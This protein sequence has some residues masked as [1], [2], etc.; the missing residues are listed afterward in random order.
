MAGNNEQSL[1]ERQHS[2]GLESTVTP[3]RVTPFQRQ[4]S[5]QPHK[6][7]PLPPI[8]GL[9]A[10]SFD[11]P[12]QLPGANQR[13]GPAES[14]Q[15]PAT[16]YQHKLLQLQQLHQQNQRAAQANGDDNDYQIYGPESIATTNHYGYYSMRSNLKSAASEF[17][18]I[19]PSSSG[20]QAAP[21]Q[22]QQAQSTLPHPQDQSFLLDS[23]A[24][25]LPV[26]PRPIMPPHYTG[27]IQRRGPQSD[28]NNNSISYAHQE[29]QQHPLAGQFLVH[30]TTG[31][32][33]IADFPPPTEAG[34]FEVADLIGPSR[35]LPLKPNKRRT[36]SETTASGSL[37]SS[38]VCFFRRAFSRQS[39]RSNRNQKLPESCSSSL[40]A[41]DDGSYLA[42]NVQLVVQ[43]AL[44]AGSQSAEHEARRGQS[45]QS[46]RMVDMIE[47]ITNKTNLIESAQQ[48]QRM[49][50]ARPSMSFY[51]SPR[52][53]VQA[54]RQGGFVQR[55][56]F[57]APLHKS[58]SI[59]T[60][61]GLSNVHD[62]HL[63]LYRQNKQLPSHYYDNE[64]TVANGIESPMMS[65]STKVMSANLTPLFAR[66]EQLLDE[67]QQQLV[68]SPRLNAG[69]AEHLP[70]PSS[71]YGQPSMTGN[72]CGGT[73]S[74]AIGDRSNFGLHRSSLHKQRGG[75]NPSFELRRHQM[76]MKV[77]FLDPTCEVAEEVST[78]LGDESK[79]F[80][81]YEQFNRLADGSGAAISS[82]RASDRF[83]HQQQ[84]RQAVVNP[85]LQSSTMDTIYDNH[86]LLNR[87]RNEMATSYSHYDNHH[88][89]QM[90]LRNSSAIDRLSPAPKLINSAGETLLDSPQSLYRANMMNLHHQQQ[91]QQQ[92]QQQHSTPSHPGPR[93]S[94]ANGGGRFTVADMMLA[95]GKPAAIV[96]PTTPNHHQLL[97]Y[98]TSSN[99]NESQY[100]KRNPSQQ[101][102]SSLMQSTA[103]P[104]SS[105]RLLGQQ[106]Q[107]QHSGH[108]QQSPLVSRQ[109]R[110]MN[111]PDGVQATIVGSAGGE[112]VT[113]Q[114]VVN[115]A[116][117]PG[118][119]LEP[120]LAA[121]LLRG[122]NIDAYECSTSGR[123][124]S[125]LSN[126]K[127]F[128]VST[129][130]SKSMA[131]D[132]QQQSAPEEGLVSPLSSA[133]AVDLATGNLEL[134][135]LRSSRDELS[136][137]SR[138]AS[139]SHSSRTTSNSM[140]APS[141]S[142]AATTTSSQEEDEQ[143]KPHRRRRCNE[144]DGKRVETRASEATR[145][146]SNNGGRRGSHASS[147]ESR[148]AKSRGQS[149]STEHSGETNSRSASLDEPDER[150]WIT[151]KLA[152]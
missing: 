113:N 81:D 26:Q 150:N 20:F 43:S 16:S 124:K 62:E 93:S 126:S 37:A 56:Q 128:L 145:S 96:A 15:L 112:L 13:A 55:N 8:G 118:I 1:S 137:G 105:P 125:G 40:G 89:L 87:V 108:Y 23:R 79:A 148:S 139:S 131:S 122:T 130:L 115:I 22:Q 140:K 147:S 68:M 25:Q 84:Q 92:L 54:S 72:G 27:S 86:P 60:S 73:S 2:I 42:P 32:R 33:L 138:S 97:A 104:M 31:E 7:R 49:G 129:R 99:S 39:K 106:H 75:Q 98:S 123:P 57:G 51:G 19:R 134:S 44:S 5:I 95:N 6:L 52:Q 47:A 9:H 21:P 119:N 10:A 114:P 83:Q 12:L 121:S 111:R 90:E 94:A 74:P 77:P 61:M 4:H 76:L 71:I 133:N 38:I 41:F 53:V 144:N 85:I 142:S 64:P 146:S 110:V 136:S 117:A 34:G 100:S 109:S 88:N 78:P 59:S 28:R 58:N 50:G 45:M 14:G 24:T 30:P 143:Q 103:S 63:Q 17:S 116:G 80:V 91:L 11:V 65:R 107:Q 151:S 141:A 67:K 120:S 127:T 132:G 101:Q 18:F 70:R 102:R 29:Q 46:A 149:S 82:P 48:Q 3:L 152:Q 35:Q 66:R 36:V 135:P 69:R